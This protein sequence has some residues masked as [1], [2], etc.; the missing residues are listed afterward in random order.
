[1]VQSLM[2]EMTSTLTS[3]ISTG[4]ASYENSNQDT[5]R[6]LFL[7]IYVVLMIVDIWFSVSLIYYG[8]KTGK[9]RRLETKNP[10]SLNSG[11]IYLSVIVCS[12]AAFFYHL[13]IAIYRN[14][15][16]QFQQNWDELCDSMLDTVQTLFGICVITV[17]CFLWLRQRMLYTTFLPTAQFTKALKFFSFIIIFITISGCVTAIILSVVPNDVVSSSIGC[18]YQKDG[19]LRKVSLIF[20]VGSLIFGQV[21]LLAVFIH[22]LLVMHGSNVEQKWKWLP[23]CNR[24]SAIEQTNVTQQPAD[25]TKKIVQN[26]IRKTTIFAA[27]S[28]L[29]DLVVVT[30]T[31]LFYQSGKRNEYVS[32]LGSLAVS[33]NVCFVVL[34][35]A[36]WKDMIMSPCKLVTRNEFESRDTSHTFS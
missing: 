35:F 17:F 12:V 34:S 23:C 1:M 13:A 4:T 15:E 27:L 9:W 3:N 36:T 2:I 33:M 20:S 22:A 7:G 32:V 25:R 6:F 14:I 10:D 30:L 28:L 26:I 5:T 18:V 31:M 11:R 21:S 24:E 29:S 19:N 8:I 16:Y